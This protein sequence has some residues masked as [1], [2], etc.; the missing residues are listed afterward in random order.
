MG[1]RDENGIGTCGSDQPGGW[2]EAIEPFLDG[3]LTA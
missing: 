2:R 1:D 3:V